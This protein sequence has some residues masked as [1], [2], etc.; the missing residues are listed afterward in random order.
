MLHHERLLPT[1]RK[2]PAAV[3]PQHCEDG[4]F[5]AMT[6]TVRPLRRNQLD[7]VLHEAC[8]AFGW[9]APNDLTGADAVH[10]SRCRAARAPL[11][12]EIVGA[13]AVENTL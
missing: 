6:S 11:P 5:A 12:V 8:F 9:E 13:S 3:Q 1:D 10:P 7:Q 4:V 2:L